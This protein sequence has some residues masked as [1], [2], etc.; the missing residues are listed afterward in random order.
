MCTLGKGAKFTGVSLRQAAY[1]PLATNSLSKCTSCIPPPSAASFTVPEAVCDPTPAAPASAP[2]SH[3][4]QPRWP[5]FCH[6]HKPYSFCLQSPHCR[7]LRLACP[8]ST[9]GSH[10]DPRWV[11]LLQEMLKSPFRSRLLK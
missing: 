10:L 2:G 7:S 9:E 3:S 1:S 4:A 5:A 6:S 8:S 11:S